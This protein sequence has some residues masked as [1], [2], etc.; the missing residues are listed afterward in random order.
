[1]TR[2]PLLKPIGLVRAGI[3][4][5]LAVLGFLV[6][7]T[8]GSAYYL[9][10]S[11]QETGKKQELFYCEVLP[12]I[13]GAEIRENRDSFPSIQG[14]YQNTKVKIVPLEDNLCYR[15]LPRLYLRIYLA[16][17]NERQFRIV[18]MDERKHLFP[19]AA[20]EKHSMMIGQNNPQFELLLP[21]GTDHQAFD[22][23]SLA[24]ILSE[25]K[26]CSEILFQRRFIRLTL[27]IAKGERAHYAILR[28]AK[29]PVLVLKNESFERNIKLLL[30][31]HGEV[32][33]IESTSEEKNACLASGYCRNNHS[34]FRLCSAGKT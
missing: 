22:N 6:L 14:V 12:H 8:I 34:E 27:L 9:M 23:I 18:N 15:G 30:K 1:M 10:R 26:D 17:D 31:L 24:E 21:E 2:K 33:K 5:L 28:A 20:F 4:M 7:L 13:K 3:D 32:A 19:P 29:F 16:V 11:H 25:I